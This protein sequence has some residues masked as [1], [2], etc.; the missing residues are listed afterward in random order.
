MICTEA[1]FYKDVN[2]HENHHKPFHPPLFM[3]F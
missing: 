2:E 3:L 1:S